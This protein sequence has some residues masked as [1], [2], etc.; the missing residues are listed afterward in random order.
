MEY[1]SL[2]RTGAQVSMLCLGCMNFGWGTEEADAIAVIHRALDAGINFLDTANVYARGSSE[3]MTGKALTNGRR[4]RVFLAT[5][6]HGKMGEEPND[7]GNHRFHIMRQCEESLKRLGT[8]HIDLYQIHRPQPSVPIDET[9][10]ALDDLVRQGKIRYI[11]TSTFAAWQL[12]ESL[13][14]SKELGLNRFACEQPPYHI[15]DRRIERE[16]IPFCQT[17]GFGIIP[18]SP[19]AGG[20]LTGKYRRGGTGPEGSRYEKGGP[21]QRFTEAA[22]NIVD[23]LRPIVEEKGC[24]MSQFALAWCARQPGVTS[25]IIG[26]RTMEQLED[27]LKAAEIAIT[28]ED[29]Q[30][31]DSLVKPGTHVSEYYEADFGPHPHRW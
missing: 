24:S 19:L 31:I 8:D 26:P 18:W 27:N 3:Q 22:L 29:R 16:L 20:L 28:D 25:P 1:R 12:C 9:L 10:R 21:E 15:L 6:V 2:G 13:W 30:K 4:D 23:A 11:G 7:W 17:Y 5:K 14:V